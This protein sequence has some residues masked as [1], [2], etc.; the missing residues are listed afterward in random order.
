MIH[1]IVAMIIAIS[2]LASLQGMIY[3]TYIIII[4]LGLNVGAIIL[5]TSLSMIRDG[6]NSPYMME[7]FGSIILVRI[8]LLL[9]I[10]HI[11][12]IGYTFIA[13]VAAATVTITILSLIF[14]KLESLDEDA[15]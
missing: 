4:M 1:V 14:R 9:S 2:L 13:G 7:N 12:M 5:S 15:E 6:A 8:M 3:G 10:W 11:Y